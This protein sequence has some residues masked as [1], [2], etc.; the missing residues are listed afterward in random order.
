VV[1][2]KEKRIRLNITANA[3][4]VVFSVLALLLLLETGIR[5]Y[6]TVLFPKLMVLDDRVG[7]RHAN[8]VSRTLL[9]EFGAEVPVIQNA[10]GHRGKFHPLSKPAGSF[11]I[12]AL[13]DSFTEGVQVGERELFSAQLE[14]AIP[15]LEVLNAGV[16]GYGTVQ[17]YLYLESEGLQFKPNLVL[18]MFFENDLTD[19]NLSYYPAFGPRPYARLIGKNLEIVR[20]L[21]SSE[22]EKFILPF[23]FRMALNKYS[24]FYY[25]LNSRIY[26][27]F[28]TKRMQQ[29]Q[30]SDL[31]R[32][33]TDQMYAIFYGVLDTFRK[34]L[35]EEGISFLVVLI[36]SREEATKGSSQMLS[37]ISEHCRMQN[38]DC[39][40]LLDR[41]HHE[42]ATGARPY[43]PVD[44]HWTHIGHQI[45]ADEIFKYLSSN[46]NYWKTPANGYTAQDSTEN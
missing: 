46:K 11:R 40:S 27:P 26:Q 2:N 24:Y 22:Y 13:G 16:G 43:F 32:M 14:S 35:N 30:Q 18:L 39:L 31:E 36:P 3:A 21:D 4:L 45:A 15:H 41:L 42:I 29:M 8:N 9:N 5:V 34:R 7:W 28:F 10:Y 25:F 1:A 38:I 17:E 20:T 12:L 37:I 23:P 44:M 33:D 19:N 6:A